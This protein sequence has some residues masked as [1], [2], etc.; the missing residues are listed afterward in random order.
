[1]KVRV[2]R[3]HLGQIVM[4]SVLKSLQIAQIEDYKQRLLEVDRAVKSC[5][6][7]IVR[8][9]NREPMPEPEEP[10]A[11]AAKEALPGSEG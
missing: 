1:M 11:G 6:E 7:E 2:N 10:E 9:I 3:D 4:S 5:V 8:C